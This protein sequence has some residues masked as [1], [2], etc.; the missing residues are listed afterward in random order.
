MRSGTFIQRRRETKEFLLGKRM[1]A[2][3]GASHRKQ[4]LGAHSTRY[5]KGVP[6]AR[7]CK[8]NRQPELI[9]SRVSHS[10]QSPLP[11]INRQLSGTRSFRL[12]ALLVTRH[13][14]ALPALTKEGSAREGSLVTAFLIETRTGLFGCGVLGGVADVAAGYEVDD[15]F[16]DVYGAGAGVIEVLFAGGGL[17]GGREL[18][19]GGI[20]DDLDG[21]PAGIRGCCARGLAR[22][23]GLELGIVKAET[24][25][26]VIAHDG[27]A[28]L[29]QHE[30]LVRI[31]SHAG[32]NDDDSDA[33]FVVSEELAGGT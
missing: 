10:K 31:T 28:G 6:I 8:I 32:A 21:A 24:V 7:L 16:G 25:D 26:E 13:L 30:V 11:K 17:L 4:G 9:E 20:D 19:A 5:T 23:D 18:G 22:A 27:G 29:R 12:S 3:S 14:L 2:E 33:K 1:Q 15:V